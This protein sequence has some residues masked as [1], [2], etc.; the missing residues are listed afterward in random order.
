[1]TIA[2]VPRVTD[3]QADNEFEV[4]FQEHYAMVYRTAYS[5][6]DNTADAEDVLQTVFLR[7]I[8]R[9]FAPDFRSNARGY[10]Y[11]AAVNVALDLIRRRKR[12]Q[13]TADIEQFEISVPPPDT[14]DSDRTQ[15]IHDRLTEAIAELSPEAAHILILRYVHDYSDAE[16]AKLLGRSRTAIA[17]GLFRSRARLRKLL[18]GL[19]GE[20]S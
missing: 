11:R 20:E 6:L 8:R 9:E 15:R 13:L 5:I 16:I 12:Y 1:M 2:V 10:F 19:Q 18:R 14:D 17:V 3:K 7:L 4:L